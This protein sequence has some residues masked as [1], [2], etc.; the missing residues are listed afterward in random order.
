MSFGALESGLRPHKDRLVLRQPTLVIGGPKPPVSNRARSLG[1]LLKH[2]GSA[3]R[4]SGPIQP[5]NDACDGAGFIIKNVVSPQLLDKPD[6]L[7]HTEHLRAWSVEIQVATQRAALAHF[8]LPQLRSGVVN[9]VHALGHD[10]QVR[11]CTWGLTK[12]Q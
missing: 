2:T 7:P 3:R 10:Q 12:L 5:R 9:E 4:A 11:G 1:A 6:A 8:T